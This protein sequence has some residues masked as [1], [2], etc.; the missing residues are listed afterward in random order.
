MLLR[1]RITFWVAGGFMSLTLLVS[2]AA[3]LRESILHERIAQATQA[4]QT[5]LWNEVVDV[6]LATMAAQRQQLTLDAGFARSV[7][8]NDHSEAIQ[9][10]QRTGL[11]AHG[12]EPTEFV[13][14]VGANREPFF[15]A[16]VAASSSVLDATVIDKVM[17]GKQAAGLRI[18]PS[19]QAY[20]VSAQTMTVGTEEFVLIVGRSARSALARFA[21]HLGGEASLITIRA[22]LAESTSPTLHKAVAQGV[23]PRMPTFQEVDADTRSYMVSGVPIYEVSGSSAGSLVLIEDVTTSRAYSR[24]LVQWTFFSTLFF[25]LLG[26]IV[27]NGLL[28]RSFRPLQTA[29]D[30]LKALSRGDAHV[31]L[32][33]GRSD[34]IGQ[35]ADAVVVFRQ[36]AQDLIANRAL[37]ERIRRRQESVIQR[38]IKVLSTVS[39]NS[40]DDK[41]LV[42]LGD[43]AHADR[44]DDSLRRLAMVLSGMSGRIVRQ[45]NIL[46]SMVVELREALRVKTQYVAL[47]HELEIAAKM[48]SAILPKRFV[49]RAGLSISASM[50]PAKEIGGDFYDYFELDDHRVAMTVADVSGKGVPA[51]LFMAVSRTLLRAV[52]KFSNNP[53]DCLGQ[54]NSLLA[55][56]NDQMMFVTL[57]YAVIDTRNGEVSYCNAG[58]NPPYVLRRD[59]KLE[60][61][62]ATQGIALAVFEDMDFELGHLTLAPGDGFFMYTDGV[63]EAFNPEGEMFEA[64]RLEA[65]LLAH[66]TSPVD[67]VPIAIQAAVKAFEAG[68]PQTDDITCLMARRT[69]MMI[70][71]QI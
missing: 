38:E 23:S 39:D 11:T 7:T 58:H 37:R 51:A 35:I 70:E 21:R 45:Q 56:D 26:I 60:V 36:H 8:S 43:D 61:V 50:T 29:I 6:E 14:L 5:A 59:G 15:A 20:L 13:M 68:G 9:T 16:G 32:Q 31:Q 17:N 42:N 27:L 63:T 3:M 2:G 71:D 44:P 19:G 48:Q 62:P 28:W 46:T 47:Q 33:R 22:R 34:E 53:A 10:L 65:L 55:V 54:L 40:D 18:L 24:Q 69:D 66:L 4:G 30:A 25:V 64:A 41:L 1:T 49:P 52:A 67:D 12:T 57:F